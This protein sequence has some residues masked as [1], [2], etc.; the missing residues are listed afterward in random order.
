MAYLLPRAFIVLACWGATYWVLTLLSTELPPSV[1][2]ITG[3]AWLLGGVVC[4][5]YIRKLRR[6]AELAES[7]AVVR[8][9]VKAR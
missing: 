2:Y 1:V 3:I 7:A 9:K 6:D 5:G 4:F 8:S